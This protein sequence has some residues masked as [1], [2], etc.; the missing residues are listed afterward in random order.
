MFTED[1]GR[2]AYLIYN[3]VKKRSKAPR[4]VL[5]PLAILNIE[6]E[7]F[8]N[9]DIHRLK[10]ARLDCTLT[11]LFLNPSK[12]AIALFLSEVL[13]RVLQEKEPNHKLFNYL[14]HSIHRLNVIEEGTGNFHLTFLFKLSNYLGINPSREDY[15]SG[16]FFDLQDGVFTGVV[17]YHNNYLSREDSI[18]FARLLKMNFENM[19]VFVFS[20]REKADILRH[21][22]SYYRLH[23][24]DFPEIKSLDIMQSLFD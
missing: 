10:E 22:L 18:V 9:R 1:F 19:S 21:I 7:H 15:R 16:C 12:N 5:S 14:Y 11:Q 17:P 23:L 24:V 13:Y 20:R 4:S 2:V 3:N 8:N 6:A